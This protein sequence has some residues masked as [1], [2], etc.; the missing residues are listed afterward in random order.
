MHP[1]CQI[2]QT[3][4]ISTYD[5]ILRSRLVFTRQPS[6]NFDGT[7]DALSHSFLT[8]NLSNVAIEPKQSYPIHKNAVPSAYKGG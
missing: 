7:A 3:L 8:V 2:Q 5:H 4:T 6:V 1:N